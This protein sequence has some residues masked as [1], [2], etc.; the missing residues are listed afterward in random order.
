MCIGG[1]EA[2]TYVTNVYF[3]RDSLRGGLDMEMERR[4]LYEYA[5]RLIGLDGSGF[6]KER[7][8][9]NQYVFS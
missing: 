7:G 4:R 5:S 3:N 2:R 8:G 6:G 9:M 1:E